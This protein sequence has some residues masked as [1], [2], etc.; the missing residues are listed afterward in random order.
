M[1]E[2]VQCWECG[3]GEMMYLGIIVMRGDSL[4]VRAHP[5]APSSDVSEANAASEGRRSEA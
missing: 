2:E 4:P 1:E 5:V 3:K